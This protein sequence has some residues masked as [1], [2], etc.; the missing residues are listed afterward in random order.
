MRSPL[1]RNIVISAAVHVLVIAAIFVFSFRSCR[2]RRSPRE[3]TT[4][5]DLQVMTPD[6]KI[7]PAPVRD[8]IPEPAPEPISRSPTEPPKK[9]TI[10]AS[11]KLIK[12]ETPPGRKELIEKDIRQMLRVTA[13]SSRQDTVSD[14]F[15]RYLSA[16]RDVMYKVWQQPGAFSGASGL[17]TRA[18]IQVQRDG[19]IIQRKII[20]PSGHGPMDTSVASALELVERLPELPQG[21]GDYEDITIDFELTETGP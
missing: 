3:I 12:R 10:E 1:I 20:V 14:E 21:C 2:A 9:K 5:I 7:E 13:P 8:D 4:F 18:L 15:A 11:K 17:V 16:V 19:R 6:R